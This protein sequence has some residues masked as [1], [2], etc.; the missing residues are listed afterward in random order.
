MD[1]IKKLRRFAV[2]GI[3]S[4]SVSGLLNTGS[5]G[6][7]TVAPTLSDVKA[8]VV[9]GR[10]LTAPERQLL[11]TTA[12]KLMGEDPA[13]IEAIITLE[14]KAIKALPV[15]EK[16]VV[17]PTITS[18]TMALMASCTSSTS[19]RTATRYS[20]NITGDKVYRYKLTKHWSWSTCTHRV[21]DSDFLSSD[22]IEGYVYGAFQWAWDYNGT[23]SHSGNYYTFNGYTNGGHT[24]LV[25]GKFKYCI[26]VPFIG[27]VCPQTHAPWLK[28]NAH[29]NGSSAV[30][31]G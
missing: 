30:Y 6:A 16:T 31:T 22:D 18:T 19:S 23:T 4:V 9:A 28:V 5:V 13:L 12:A 11:A 27:N 3:L 29:Y 14:P 26:S 24:S 10:S 21:N 7:V 2:V 15:K 20:Y 1:T 8:S 25:R 17:S